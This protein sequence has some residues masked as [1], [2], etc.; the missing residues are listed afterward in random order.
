MGHVSHTQ[1]PSTCACIRLLAPRD[2]NLLLLK[3]IVLNSLH[4]LLTGP[5]LLRK[6]RQRRL[7]YHSPG[8]QHYDRPV[9]STIFI[10]VVKRQPS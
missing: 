10:K 9:F 5:V 8:E 2:Y 6:E 1:I 4:F 7:R 3:A